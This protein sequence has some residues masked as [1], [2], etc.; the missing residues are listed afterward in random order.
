MAGR[1][2][3]GRAARDVVSALFV[4][5]ALRIVAVAWLG[6]VQASESLKTRPG[7]MSESSP[8]ESY[9]IF[10]DFECWAKS[11][12]AGGQG[13][14]TRDDIFPR[15]KSKKFLFFFRVRRS[16]IGRIDTQNAAENSSGR[17]VCPF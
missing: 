2:A 9:E 3:G 7:S 4:R 1:A 13:V 12:G 15:K 10:R 6:D 5:T 8:L 11:R 14:T 17:G 16:I